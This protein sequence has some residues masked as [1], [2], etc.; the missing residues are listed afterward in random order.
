[1]GEQ[2]PK[3]SFLPDAGELLG[4]M[5]LDCRAPPLPRTLGKDLHAFRA[6]TLSVV[7]RRFIAGRYRDVWAEQHAAPFLVCARMPLIVPVCRYTQSMS[8]DSPHACESQPWVG[9]AVL[10]VDL[11]AFFAAVEQ[12]DHPEWRGKPVIVGGDPSRRGVVSTCSYEAR[13]FGVR[14]AMPSARAAALCPHAV[15]APPRFSRYREF[16]EAVFAIFRDESPLV[17]PVSVDEAFIDVTPGTFAS[18]H[19]VATARRIRAR[20]AELGLT[21]SVGVASSKTVAKIASD[22]EKPD[23]LTVVCPGT[24]A[25]F[26]S[27]LPVRD[28]SGV[29]PKT[30]ERLRALGIKTLG[31]LASLDDATARGVLGK[32]GPGLVLRSRGVDTRSVHDNDPAKSVSNERTFATDVRTLGDVEGALLALGAKVGQRLRRKGMTGRTVTVK[33]RF[34]D[35]TTRTIQRTLASATDD[36]TVFVPVARELLR[37]AWSPGIGVRLLGIGVSGFEER[38]EQLDLLGTIADEGEASQR[39]REGLVRGVDAVRERFGD[40][41]V[42]FGRDLRK[43]PDTGTPKRN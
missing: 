6:H 29:G 34:S 8:I 28:M 14:S 18:E 33:V 10:H 25:S 1:M 19:P 42:K 2:R 35:F 26:L 41:A 20:V 23:G 11:D 15:W 27:P 16:S 32:H 4:D 21:A 36:E 40:D 39:P 43:R 38:A 17:Q 12:L 5:R 22:H 13:V 3:R 7:Q 31:D 9:R 24:E 30:A 37:E